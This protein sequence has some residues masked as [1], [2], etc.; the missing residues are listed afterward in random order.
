[1]IKSVTTAKMFSADPFSGSQTFFSDPYRAKWQK[2]ATSKIDCGVLKVTDERAERDVHAT[3][4]VDNNII[5][6]N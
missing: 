3:D 1:M 5:N 2:P 6:K 4:K